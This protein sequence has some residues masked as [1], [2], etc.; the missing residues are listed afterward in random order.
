MR[1]MTCEPRLESSEEVSGLQEKRILGQGK[2]QHTDR[3]ETG[4]CTSSG[5]LY[6]APGARE[7]P[8]AHDDCSHVNSYS[9]ISNASE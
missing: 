9:P 3:T 4:E 6:K 8:I 5:G 7:K 1:K 2:R